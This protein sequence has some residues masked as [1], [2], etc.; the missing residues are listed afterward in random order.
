MLLYPDLINYILKNPL[1][2]AKTELNTIQGILGDKE[3]KERE[4]ETL[5]KKR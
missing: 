1:N 3:L 5:Q 2:E 4:P